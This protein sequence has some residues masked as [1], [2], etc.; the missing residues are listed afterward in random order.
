MVLQVHRLVVNR[1]PKF[2]NFVEVIF[3]FALNIYLFTCFIAP[4]SWIY[5]T[6]KCFLL[7]IFDCELIIVTL[8]AVPYAQGDLQEICGAV[9]LTV[10]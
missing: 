7:V 5:C 8:L 3:S 1:D 9:F 10:C 4:K 6:C 2:T